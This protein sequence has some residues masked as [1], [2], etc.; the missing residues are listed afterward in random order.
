M[1]LP[2]Y[3][4]NPR[5]LDGHHTYVT[6]ENDKNPIEMKEVWY[7]LTTQEERGLQ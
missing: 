3:Y 6:L 5:C 4:Q 2:W 7:T 1:R